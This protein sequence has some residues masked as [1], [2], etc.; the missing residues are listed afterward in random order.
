MKF[1]AGAE[2]QFTDAIAAIER[3]SAAEVVVTVRGRLDRW[4]WAHVGVAVVAIALMLAY[5]LWSE[6]EFELWAILVMP[7]LAGLTGGLAVELVPALERALVPASVRS[8]I[9][10]A[11]ARASFVELGVHYTR[12]RT[13][14][15]VF[16]AVRERTVKWIGDREVV[17]K[18]GDGGLADAAASL[19]R[20]IGRGGAAVANALAGCREVLA[21]ALPRA[22]DDVNELPDTIHQARR[23][24]RAFRGGVR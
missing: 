17:T 3:A 15:L 22:V 1:M 19:E 18:L 5:G 24:R 12:D 7:L 14:I 13:G 4:L 21:T 6:T 8:S 20:E 2:Q 16:I 11:A 23:P 9:A 10:L